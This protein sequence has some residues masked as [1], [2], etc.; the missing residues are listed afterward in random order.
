MK[1]TGILLLLGFL[2]MVG[3]YFISAPT[4]PA[5][6]TRDVVLEKNNFNNGE[7]LIPDKQVVI[8]PFVE[9][10]PINASRTE[11]DNPHLPVVYSVK[12]HE[13]EP[14]ENANDIAAYTSL[15]EGQSRTFLYSSQY[16]AE[17]PGEFNHASDGYFLQPGQSRTF[18]PLSS[19]QNIPAKDE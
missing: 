17:T 4:V 16:G 8:N 2:I 9:S 13:N 6:V 12:H 18:L 11:V 5:P 15:E 7:S 19:E 14:V 3:A 1:I 10:V